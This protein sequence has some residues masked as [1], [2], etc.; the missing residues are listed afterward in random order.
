MALEANTVDKVNC[1][2]QQPEVDH[3]YKGE[4]SDA[5]YDDEQFWRRTRSYITYQLQ[6]KDQ[7][8]KSIDIRALDDI[9]PDKVIFLVNEKPADI[10]SVS[11]KTVRLKADSRDVIVLKIIAQEGKSTPRFN[12]IRLLTQ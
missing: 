1:G 12:Q 6:N 9:N 8:G 5:G 7:A 11:G 2:E 3:Q 4:K 10:S